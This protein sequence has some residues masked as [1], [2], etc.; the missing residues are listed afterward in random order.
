MCGGGFRFS[1]LD[2]PTSLLVSG[3]AA[4]LEGGGGGAGAALVGR[5]GAG[6]LWW[7]ST[8]VGAGAAFACPF[9]GAEG[10]D[11]STADTRGFLPVAGGGTAAAAGGGEGAGR[12]AVVVGGTAFARDDVGVDF[13]TAFKGR[14]EGDFLEGAFVATEGMAGVFFVPGSGVPME[15]VGG[16]GGR[17]TS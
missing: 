7:A 16:E 2:S 8:A 12:G 3:T 4:A 15:R 17:T 14:G 10:A 6:G 5:L 1:S 13:S 9:A 11:V